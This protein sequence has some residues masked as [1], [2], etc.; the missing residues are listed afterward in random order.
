MSQD[1]HLQPVFFDADII[2]CAAY[3]AHYNMPH[4]QDDALQKRDIARNLLCVRNVVTSTF[5]MVKVFDALTHASGLD[6]ALAQGWVDTL[7][8]ETLVSL[9]KEDVL[10]SLRLAKAYQLSVQNG[11]S[12]HAAARAQC[13]I[14]YT[15]SLHHGQ[16]YGS[17]RACN[18]FIV[19]FLDTI[20]A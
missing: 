13:S 14:M 16:N 12:L 5:V 2:V 4:T 7:A 8:E 17:I 20:Q 15:Q 11:I 10:E 3:V 18:P 19:D 6:A 9:N 1:T